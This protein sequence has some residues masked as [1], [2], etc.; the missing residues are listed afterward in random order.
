MR[1]NTRWHVDRDNNERWR[2]GGNLFPKEKHFFMQFTLHIQ[3][4]LRYY[5]YLPV[6]SIVNPVKETKHP[7]QQTSRLRDPLMPQLL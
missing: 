2:Q 5:D 4:L 3:K 6:T 7:N 1:H